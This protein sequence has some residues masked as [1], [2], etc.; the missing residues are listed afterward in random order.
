MKTGEKPDWVDG[1]Q[2]NMSQQI[3]L[4]RYTKKG[5]DAAGVKADKSLKENEFIIR[6]T[7]EEMKGTGSEFVG[8]SHD[9]LRIKDN[10]VE[11]NG[12]PDLGLI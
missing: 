3:F 8:T 7:I 5:D 11:W 6:A 10:K 1:T 9:V 12:L 4:S 2:R